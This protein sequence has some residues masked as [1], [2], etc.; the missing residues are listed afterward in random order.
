MRRKR[1]KARNIQEECIITL[2]GY[3]YGCNL[4]KIKIVNSFT[5][6]NFLQPRQAKDATFYFMN[7]MLCRTLDLF[8][9][10]LEILRQYSYNPIITGDASSSV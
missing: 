2:R 10:H 4:Y 1:Q 8:S 6:S 5:I 3:N 7:N 9:R